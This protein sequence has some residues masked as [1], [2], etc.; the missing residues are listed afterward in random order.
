[1]LLKRIVKESKE[2]LSLKEAEKMHALL[3]IKCFFGKWEKK[4][5]QGASRTVNGN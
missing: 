2:R 4:A 5:K 3:E 1:M